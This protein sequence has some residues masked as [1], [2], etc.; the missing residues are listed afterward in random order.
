MWK[1]HECG[2]QFNFQKLTVQRML[3]NN[4]SA[5]V[6]TVVF[7]IILMFALGFIAE[8]IISF[9]ID[10]YDTM[11]GREPLWDDLELELPGR[12]GRLSAWGQHFAKGFI[13]VGV[14]G[15]IKMLL[16]NPW[17]WWN[18]RNSGLMGSRRTSA[19]GRDRSVNFN[20]IFVLIGIFSAF[21]FF[22][23][24]VQAIIQKSLA[25]IGNHIVDTQLPGDDD[26]LKPPPGW[27]YEPPKTEGDSKDQP[28]AE[29]NAKF[30]EDAQ[31]T[32]EP[33][34]SEHMPQNGEGDDAA[35]SKNHNHD[36]ER[37]KM[38]GSW[39]MVD[40]LED[41]SN[42]SAGIQGMHRQGWSFSNL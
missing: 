10:P 32:H 40:E 28:N 41:G 1:C 21:Y 29:T 12:A 9:Y 20:W 14:V 38:A 33:S 42:Q 11:M 35:S 22:Y 18:L 39:F 37:P 4:F 25:R 19:T 8:P 6:F 24:W 3:S 34:H 15:F 5:A 26:D 13:S 31:G 23:Q 16:M 30:N 27:K 7:M 17:N 36:H 2:H